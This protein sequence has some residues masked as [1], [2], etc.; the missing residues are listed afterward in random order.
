MMPMNW[1]QFG[2]SVRSARL[3]SAADEPACSE[4]RKARAEI[5]SL[6]IMVRS[7]YRH[8]PA[9]NEVS[10]RSSKL[11]HKMFTTTSRL[12]R[13]ARKRHAR[14]G[15]TECLQLSRDA[16]ESG[17][18]DRKYK[19]YFGVTSEYGCHDKSPR[20]PT[21]RGRSGPT[22]WPRRSSPAPTRPRTGAATT[23]PAATTRPS[24]F[25]PR[26][27]TLGTRRAVDPS[28]SLTQSR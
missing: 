2:T 26:S 16:R 17:T 11:H 21:Q 12:A 3:E 18:A 14:P 8:P 15:I 19:R 25:S 4:L 28:T 6:S 9:R 20:E 7:L 22:T 27:L 13:R 5:C 10:R 24:P 23:P 1:P